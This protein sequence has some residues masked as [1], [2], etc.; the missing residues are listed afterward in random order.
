MK[1]NQTQEKVLQFAAN[2]ELRTKEQMLSL[3]LAEGIKF[4]FFDREPISNTELD[5]E[6][7]VE[8][9][10]EDAMRCAISANAVG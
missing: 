10:T 5:V 4:Y 3:L 6:R 1:L 2:S 9:M 8:L 7:A